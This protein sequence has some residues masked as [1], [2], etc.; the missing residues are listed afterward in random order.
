MSAESSILQAPPRSG[1][2]AAKTLLLCA[3]IFG[4]T[5]AVLSRALDNGFINFDD[6]GY[7]TDNRNVK[8]GLSGDSIS[9]AFRDRSQSNWHPLTWMSH[10]LDVE[11]FDL[12][13][14]GHHLTSVL[15]HALNAALVVA[16]IM[17]WTGSV[18]V[19]VTIALLFALHPTRV[20][21]VAWVSERKDV[22]SAF[23]GLLTLLFYSGYARRRSTLWYTAALLSFSLGLMA[24]PM[25]VTLPFLMLLL[26][27]WPLQRNG[28]RWR[29]VV[30]GLLPFFVLAIAA[31][32]VAYATQAAGGSVQTLEKYP[33]NLRLANAVLSVG[34]YLLKTVWPTNLAIFYPYP[35]TMP[36]A[37]I[38]VSG[39]VVIGVSIAAI[40]FVKRAPAV[41]VGW[42]W[43]LGMLMPVIGVVQIGRQSMADRYLYLPSVGLLIAIVFTIKQLLPRIEKSGSLVP[44]CVAAVALAMAVKTFITIG[45]WHDSKT[46]FTHAIEVTSDNVLAHHQLANALAVDRD[47]AGAEREYRTAL[48]IDPNHGKSH[49]NLGNVLAREGDYPG[50]LAELDRAIA[51]QPDMTPAY[52]SRGFVLLKLN[53]PDAAEPP[54]RRAVELDPQSLNA[55][56]QLARLLEDKRDYP[57]AH[58]QY[59]AAL[60]IDPANTTAAAGAAR[61]Q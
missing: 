47:F 57:A 49:L 53:R 35:S 52:L 21:S 12:E 42:F 44:V 46:L 61:T 13:P 31:S 60:Q 4:I 37:W 19:S 41:F 29:R 16:L 17:Q 24:K 22:L 20:E 27:V 6:P 50:A 54:L 58:V 11:I 15:L 3:I 23:F 43:F 26:H 9:W 48:A 51:L 14:W 10:M 33:L 7:V 1:P 38:A 25:L 39:V 18:G 59:T 34:R 45:Y 8:S 32:V 28:R 2:P 30:I 5:F 55:R 56:L 40:A 36:Y